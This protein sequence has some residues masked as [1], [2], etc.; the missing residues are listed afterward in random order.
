MRVSF[1]TD[2][3]V[4]YV[5][6]LDMARAWA[7]ALRRAGLPL[8]YKGEFNPQPRIQ[9]AAALPVGTTGLSEIVDIYLLRTMNPPE[10]LDRLGPALPTGIR[11]TAGQLVPAELPSLQSLVNAAHYRVDVETGES[12]QAFQGRLDAFLIRR[13]AW[14]ERRRGKE[15]ARYDLR[16]LVQSLHYTGPGE[17]GQSFEAA[18]RAEPGATGR[19]DELL[20][21]LGYGTAPRQIVRLRLLFH[22]T[23]TQP[24]AY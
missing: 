1:A 22:E 19:P 4:K 14:R 16:P 20:A 8:A 2:D 7:R 11:A 21:E 5:G 9:F 15:E 12:P 10:F 18:M 17:W 23:E 6:H 13:E 24:C 3:S